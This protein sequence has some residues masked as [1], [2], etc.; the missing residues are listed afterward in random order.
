MVTDISTL[1]SHKESV[2]LE[3]KRALKGI[4]QSLWETYVSFANTQGGTILLGVEERRDGSLQVTGLSQVETMISDIH[5]TLNNPNKVSKNILP[6]N[7][8]TVETVDGKQILRI[9]VPPAN[10]E[11]KPLYL[12]NDLFGFTFRRGGEGDYHCTKQEIQLMLRDA[13]SYSLDGSMLEQMSLDALCFETVGRYRRS[14]E[15]LKPTLSWNVL[16]DEMFLYRLNAVGKSKKDGSYHPTLAGLLMFGYHF[17]IVK[18]CPYY[19]LDYREEADPAVRWSDRLV[20]DAATWS[21]NVYDFFRLVAPKL[22]IGLRI[23]FR[24][25]GMVRQDDTVVHQAIRE[26][27]VNCLVHAQFYER[28]GV[29]ILKGRDWFSFANPGLLRV[30]KDDAIAGG[31]SDPR[32]STLFTMFTL[33]NMGERAGSGLSNIFSVWQSQGWDKPEL[34]EYLQPER[35]VL[36]LQMASHDQVFSVPQ[37]CHPDSKGGVPSISLDMLTEQQKRVLSFVR[38]QGFCTKAQ[39]MSLLDLQA[40]RTREILA[41]LIKMGLLTSEGD[42]KGRV[43][44]L[45]PFV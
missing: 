26:S 36:Y 6:G 12:N 37:I 20:S 9:E 32:N 17:E 14:F 21:G 33:L 34:T 11:D 2:Q 27:L 42:R 1:L 13:S 19:L 45:K 41:A 22:E 23:P 28:R 40:S 24:V 31:L 16:S 10:R 3:V 5:S 29:V 39:V 4:P 38:T 25:S 7:A 30:P 18:E 8:I 43:Y 15:A 35:T 44:R